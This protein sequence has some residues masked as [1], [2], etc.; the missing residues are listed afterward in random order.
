MMRFAPKT[1]A[2]VYS[3]L[4]AVEQPGLVCLMVSA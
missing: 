3:P 1:G 2:P 4:V